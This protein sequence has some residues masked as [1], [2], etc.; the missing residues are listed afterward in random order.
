MARVRWPA[1]RAVALLLCAVGAPMARGHVPFFEGE[2]T[3]A[4]PGPADDWSLDKP[5]EI[6]LDSDEGRTPPMLHAC[7]RKAE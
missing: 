7:A 2:L 5:F 3:F 6:P 4:N 1:P